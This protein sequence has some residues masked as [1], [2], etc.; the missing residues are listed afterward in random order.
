MV[1]HLC[2]NRDMPSKPNKSPVNRVRVQQLL[3]AFGHPAMDQYRTLLRGA[4]RVEPRPDGTL[5]VYSKGKA[6]APKLLAPPVYRD[7]HAE[8]SRLRAAHRRLAADFVNGSHPELAAEMRSVCDE[9]DALEQYHTLVNA[10][11][12]RAAAATALEVTQQRSRAANAMLSA[13]ERIAAYKRVGG[14]AALLR[15]GTEGTPITYFVVELPRVITDSDDA[16][17]EK[18]TKKARTLSPSAVLVRNKRVKELVMPQILGRFPLERLPVQMR[19]VEECTS[20]ARSK[21]YYM[22]KE[23]LLATID[24]DAELQHFFGKGYRGM[25]KEQLCQ[26]MFR[27]A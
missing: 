1:G 25:T 19:S 18:T 9:A 27:P 4:I 6:A 22:T 11:A 7:T 23:Q 15:K 10:P 21:P 3:D 14:L 17:K 8:I 16:R 24:S 12:V 5:A 20:K 26:V 2:S 13:D